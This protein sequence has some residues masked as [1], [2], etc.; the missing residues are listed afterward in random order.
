MSKKVP[1]TV[2][3]SDVGRLSIG[4]NPR[5]QVPFI[6]LTVTPQGVPSTPTS[7]VDVSLA[8]GVC[9]WK[10]ANKRANI[11]SGTVYSNP[12]V[13]PDTGREL[14]GFLYLTKS[15]F[16]VLSRDLYLL[17]IMNTGPYGVRGEPTLTFED[18]YKKMM[19]DCIPDNPD[20][21]PVWPSPSPSLSPLAP[22]D[23][24]KTEKKLKMK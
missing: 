16:D 1:I 17:Y 6:G 18:Y 4:H 15:G 5:A 22:E 14:S 3:A 12:P 11:P 7:F 20:I 21:Q 19:K 10:L 8:E 24:P 13:N 23:A 9:G 2:K